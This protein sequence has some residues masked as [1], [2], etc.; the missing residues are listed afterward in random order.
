M[1]GPPGSPVLKMGKNNKN[2]KSST[3]N[4]RGTIIQ[5][6][7][8][9]NLKYDNTKKLSNEIEGQ[10]HLII[11]RTDE[12][13]TMK[14]ISPILLETALNAAT[15]NSKLEIKMLKS[16]DILIKTENT[17]TANNLIKLSGIMEANVTVTEHK[18]LNSSKGVISAYELKNEEHERLL[19]YLKSQNVIDLKLHT[20]T[21]NGATYQ[22]GLVFL[23]F[24]TGE[25]PEYINVGLL[26]LRVR[27]YIPNPIR[28]FVCHKFGHISQHCS[29]KDNPS[30]YNCNESKHIYN[31]EEKCNKIAKCANCKTEGHNAYNRNCKEYKRQIEIQTVKTTQKVSFSEAVKRVNTNNKT[32]AQMTATTSTTQCTC[33]HCEYHSNS[34]V[35]SNID[36]KNNNKRIRENN[37][38]QENSTE[39]EDYKKMRVSEDKILW[40]D[41]DEITE[42]E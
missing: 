25:L 1:T 33:S 9:K 10:K 32:Y 26:R 39:D 6:T 36:V 40:T 11:H 34:Q 42:N 41:S 13:R 12:G 35:K 15:N 18:T 19:Q 21:F 17:K 20:K 38:S 5:T 4:E 24:G 3:Q 37:S 14:D 30:C 7:L 8:T 23:T 28:C 2:S 27:P 31:K 16:G 29:I 22:T